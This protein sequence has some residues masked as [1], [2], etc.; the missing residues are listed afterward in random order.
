[1]RDVGDEALL[2]PGQPLELPDLRLE[3]VGHVV[4]G[5]SQLGEVVV[6]PGRQAFV[7]VT[8]GQPLGDSGCPTDRADD[9][10]GDDIGDGREQD[11]EG[12]GA[13]S[14]GARDDA[15]GPLLLIHREDDVDVVRAGSRHD[16]LRPDNDGRHALLDHDLL[17]GLRPCPATL[18]LDGRRLL[19]ISIRCDR[20]L[21]LGRDVAEVDPASL[22]EPRL[23]RGA[24]LVVALRTGHHEV[25]GRVVGRGRQGRADDV[26]DRLRELRRGL[27]LVRL[28]QRLLRVVRQ[29]TGDRLGGRDPVRDEP[30][31]DRAVHGHADDAHGDEAEEHRRRD[32]PELEAAAPPVDEPAQ[33]PGGQGE[34]SLRGGVRPDGHPQAGPAL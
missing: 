26:V 18:Q 14:D 10:T 1:M 11:D 7:E 9:L 21:Q 13:E 5:P 30:L 23:E 25:P 22:D 19:P 33:Q 15:E 34:R 27:G 29:L 12:E 16:D 24:R 31:G 8:R 3:A 2:D 28:V 32:D 4:E 6:P 17:G 20:L